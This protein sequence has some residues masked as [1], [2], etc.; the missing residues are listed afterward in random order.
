M[1]DAAFMRATSRFD[2]IASRVVDVVEIEVGRAPG[3]KLVRRAPAPIKRPVVVDDHDAVGHY[4][5]EQLIQD[6]QRR[7]VPV[8]VDP[9][10]SDRP[11]FV[12][13]SPRA[14][15]AASTTAGAGRQLSTQMP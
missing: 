15:R 7:L 9:E 3:E 14:V 10:Q 4:Q 13:D 8:G 12:S 6:E 11:D 5:I 2:E 1:S